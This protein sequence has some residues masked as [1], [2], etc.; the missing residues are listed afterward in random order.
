MMAALLGYLLNW[1]F[2]FSHLPCSL[3]ARLLAC[4]DACIHTSD[5]LWKSQDK[6]THVCR[7]AHSRTRM[8]TPRYAC[9]DTHPI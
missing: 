7:S 8:H 1:C 2:N 6:T 3:A 4:A 5:L 9:E